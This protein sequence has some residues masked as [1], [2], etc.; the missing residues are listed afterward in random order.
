MDPLRKW[1][2]ETFGLG[3]LD[4]FRLFVAWGVVRDKMIPAIKAFFWDETVFV[5]ITRAG[6]MALSVAINTG[7]IPGVS[8]TKWGW[9]LAQ[10]LPVLALFFGAGD[11]NPDPNKLQLPEK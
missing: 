7:Q 2:E 10:S 1:A 9:Y 8:T 6:I 3:Y 11:K 5:R 4:E